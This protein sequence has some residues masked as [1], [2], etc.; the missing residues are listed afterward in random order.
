MPFVVW[1]EK[2]WAGMLSVMLG[3]EDNT[4]RAA[5]FHMAMGLMTIN[6]ATNTDEIF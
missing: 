5:C 6:K 1:E 2:A 4:R 3:I